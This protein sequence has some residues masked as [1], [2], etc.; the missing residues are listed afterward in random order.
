MDDQQK[1]VSAQA[2]S[3]Q[4]DQPQGGTLVQFP[5]QSQQ[6]QEQ[7]E[8]ATTGLPKELEPFP[9]KP[10]AGELL[11]PSEQPV[12]IE[13]DVEQA[14]VVETPQAPKISE[15][16]KKVGVATPPAPA[17]PLQAPQGL[18]LKSPIAREKAEELAKGSFL[19]KNPSSSLLWLAMLVLRQLRI[20]EKE[21]HD[22]A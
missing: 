22:A 16:L 14:G 8:E 13:P 9:L 15:E 10:S 6:P 11:S 12:E 1:P 18:P 2:Q 21:K 7:P 4:T 17:T 20:K 3:A 5:P 19:F